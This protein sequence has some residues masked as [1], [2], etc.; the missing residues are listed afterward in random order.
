MNSF[1][2]MIGVGGLGISYAV[3]LPSIS[4]RGISEDAD[5]VM[6]SLPQTTISSQNELCIITCGDEK[7]SILVRD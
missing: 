1:G 7:L 5:F 2:Y 4:M 6:S 3:T